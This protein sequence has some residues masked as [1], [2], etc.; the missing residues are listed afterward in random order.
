MKTLTMLL[1]ATAAPA[2]AQLP[3][4]GD[5]RPTLSMTVTE[6]ADAAPDTATFGVGVETQAPNAQAALA[7]NSRQMAGVIAALR[8]AGLPERDI[9]TRGINLSPQYDYQGQQ[10]RFLGFQATNAVNVK[11]RDIA[12][13]GRLLDTL[14]T[15]GGN[16]IDGPN[17]SIADPSALR[18]QARLKALRTAEVQAADYAQATGHRRARLIAI[19]EGYAPF[20]P[21]PVLTMAMRSEAAAPPPPVQ[22]GEISTGVTL[23]VTYRFED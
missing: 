10:R 22:P 1:L 5:D 3:P 21:R 19:G 2:A 18:R 23:S 9:Q 17:F 6:T 16:T 7:D 13:L 14:V 12:G 4:G 20:V 8:R 11:T 15:A